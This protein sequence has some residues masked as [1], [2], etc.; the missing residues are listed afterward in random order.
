MGVDTKIPVEDV[1]KVIVQELTSPM[2]VGWSK[3][4]GG[5]GRKVTTRTPTGD[6]QSTTVEVC[7]VGR[8]YFRL[9]WAHWI[10]VTGGNNK[11]QQIEYLSLLLTGPDATVQQPKGERLTNTL[12]VNSVLPSEL[13]QMMYVW[14]DENNMSHDKIAVKVQNYFDGKVS[15]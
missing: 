12:Y 4:I 8:V 15:L 3:S 10:E 14:N 5:Y 2:P 11:D 1:R 9:G 7:A 6:L 13:R